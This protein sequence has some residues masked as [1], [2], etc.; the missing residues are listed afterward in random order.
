[1]NAASRHQYRG[2][3]VTSADPNKSPIANTKDCVPPGLAQVSNQEFVSSTDVVQ[4]S[5]TTDVLAFE[6]I[7][8]SNSHSD[9]SSFR[10]HYHESA[11]T[12]PSFSSASKSKNESMKIEDVSYSSRKTKVD[13]LPSRNDLVPSDDALVITPAR[14]VL[15]DS[16]QDSKHCEHAP[17][18]VYPNISQPTYNSL[19]Q[20]VHLALDATQPNR[21]HSLLDRALSNL[22][23]GLMLRQV[24][25]RGSPLRITTTAVRRKR[26]DSLRSSF[27]Q[28]TRLVVPSLD[29]KIFNEL[30]EQIVIQQQHHIQPLRLEECSEKDSISRHSP[31][32]H[33]DVLGQRNATG[34]RDDQLIEDEEEE[35][36]AI[37]HSLFRS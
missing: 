17:S 8:Q 18:V 37:G 27:A 28:M 20:N 32:N 33:V 5:I 11:P 16:T 10:L 35:S 6:S 36:G 25:S 31:Y 26:S 2:T 24:S 15:I 9:P 3:N 34:L 23:T 30:A 13:H 7:G 14:A 22:G 19:G 1:M 29:D 21:G 12:K 4:K